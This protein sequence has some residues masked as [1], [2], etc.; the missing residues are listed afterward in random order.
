MCTDVV[1]SDVLALARS[2]LRAAA[3]A[4]HSAQHTARSYVP[5]AVFACSRAA[6]LSPTNKYMGGFFCIDNSRFSVAR[7]SAGVTARLW[8]VRDAR[9]RYRHMPV[10]RHNDDARLGSLA[11]RPRCTASI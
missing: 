3:L 9:R 4:Q 7:T 2:Q 11:N 8:C 1:L 6:D 5:S 10:I